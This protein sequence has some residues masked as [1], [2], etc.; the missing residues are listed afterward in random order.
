MKQ[1]G[2]QAIAIN[3]G[4]A[5]REE[6]ANPQRVEAACGCRAASRALQNE[7]VVNIGRSEAIKIERAFQEQVSSIDGA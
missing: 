5:Y 1:T 3:I 6:V 4:V 2:F 7:I